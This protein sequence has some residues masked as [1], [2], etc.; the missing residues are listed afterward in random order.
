MGGRAEEAPC[1]SVDQKA[2]MDKLVGALELEEENL[3]ESYRLPWWQQQR[4]WL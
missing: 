2:K 1:R 4:F 3:C